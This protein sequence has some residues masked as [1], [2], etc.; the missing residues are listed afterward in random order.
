MT[1]DKSKQIYGWWFNTDTDINCLCGELLQVSG[2]LVETEQII[3]C[4][5]C[6]Q[7]WSAKLDIH[8]VEDENS[9]G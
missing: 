9:G 1:T 5:N 7:R 8:M 2:S 6:G 4:P 3:T